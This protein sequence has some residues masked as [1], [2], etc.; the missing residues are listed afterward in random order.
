MRDLDRRD[1]ITGDFVFITGDV[2]SNL[3]LEPILARHRARREK[4]KNAI[5]TMV[6]RESGIDHGIQS[7]TRRPVF[8]INPRVDRCLHYEEIG[9]RNGGN[10]YVAIDP[11]LLKEHEEIELREDLVDCHIDI[12]T[13]DVLAQWSDN[14]DYQTLRNSFLFGVLKDYELNGKTI[15]THIS[16]DQYAAR[17]RNLRAYDAISKDVMGRWTYPYSPDS[18]FLPR[19]NYRLAAGQHYLDGG[20]KVPRNSI[21]KGHNIIGAD[22]TIAERVL[23]RNCALGRRCK[24]GRNVQL[25]NAYIWDNVTVGDNTTISHSIIGNDVAVGA[26]CTIE[27]GSI[28]SYDVRVPTRSTISGNILVNREKPNSLSDTFSDTFSIYQPTDSDSE[29][30]DTN[31]A[32]QLYLN[33]SAASSNSSVST[34]TSQLSDDNEEPLETS[35]RRSSVFSDPSDAEAAQKNR[36]FHLEATSSILDGMVEGHAPD[37]I[38]LELNGYRMSVDAQPH[39][40]LSSVVSAFMKRIA[41]LTDNGTTTREA[42]KNVFTKYKALIDRVILDKAAKQKTDQVDFLLCVQ[43]DVVGR[44]KGAD[45]L[46]FV[47]KEVYDLDLVEEE[48]VLQWWEDDRSS[49]GDFGVIRGLTEQFVTFLREAEE[50]ED[51]DE[52]DEEEESG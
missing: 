51:S 50:D 41:Q 35:S 36:D 26:D 17:V 14:F 6:L 20:V 23:L 13:P 34:F 29:A 42:V 1:L 40:V 43:K 7:K 15:H 27:S 11:D 37:T 31:T 45:L 24:I 25:I 30:E 38:F 21:L 10:H 3:N 49:K 52:D 47:A 4:D 46:L 32:S 33:A 12:C 18:N 44:P 8:V 22:S 19:Q 5:M 9:H 16:A 28:L 48:G 2:V 39:A